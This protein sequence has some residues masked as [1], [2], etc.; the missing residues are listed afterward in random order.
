MRLA[1]FPALGRTTA[2]RQL[3][4]VAVKVTVGA[5]IVTTA[6]ALG[7][8]SLPAPPAHATAALTIEVDRSLSLTGDWVTLTIAGEV[9]PEPT[10]AEVVVRIGGPAEP[11]QVGQ[12]DPQLPEAATVS[13][14]LSSTAAGSAGTEGA[15]AGQIA[16]G[17]ATTSSTN[18]GGDKQS[19]TTEVILAADMLTLPGAYLVT[20][21]MK[22]GGVVEARGT[23]WLGKVAPREAPLDL[24]FVWPVA[25]GI[26]RDPSGAFYDDVLERAVA[27]ADQSSSS[28]RALA[29]LASRF[30]GW[31]FTL[32]LEPILLTQLRDMADGYVRLDAAGGPQQVAGDDSAAKNALETLAA[33]KDLAVKGSV[34]VAV[35]P[36][37]GPALGALAAEGWRDGLEQIQLGKQEL[38][39]TL[40]MGSTLTGAYSSDLDMTTESLAFYGQASIDHVVVDGQLTA[41]LAEPIADDAV[42]ARVRDTEN[43]RV[44]LVFA[45][46]RLRSL[47]TPP[48]DTGVFFAGLAA[49]LAAM[50]RNALVI[51]PGADFDIPPSSYLQAIG[52]TLRRLEWVE[53]QTLTSL[54]RAHA[55]A[56]RPVL[57][58]R[59][60]ER[61]QG[62][63]E[64]ALLASLRTAHGAVTDL[65]AISDPTRGPVENAHRL[66][67]AAESRWWWQPQTSPQ[68]A[69]IGLAYAE[70][71]RALAQGELDK[72]RFAGV[73]PDSITGRRGMVTF[74]VDNQADY[75]V[76]VEVQ[77]TGDGLSLPDG[78]ELEVE[79]QPGRNEVAVNV[80]ASEAPYRL[81]AR[82]MAGSSV[83][84]QWSHSV[85]PL[86][87][88]TFLP[89]VV[90]GVVVIG[91]GVFLVLRLQ[92]RKRRAHA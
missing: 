57:L 11:S 27:P 52:S 46:S 32:A 49:E 24:A 37:S 23:A 15:T 78:E 48:W 13:Q 68:V 72:V 69:S 34:E 45:D 55:P 28:V 59:Y 91:G 90:L 26:H 83:L 81:D 85:R 79:L 20:V 51:V 7:L 53:T 89:W 31:Q 43:D 70:Q 84:D 66:L 42:A 88:M 5:V 12:Q 3:L 86:T 61:T 44:T 9:S 75:S 58:E 8:L 25:L 60:A 18:V 2:S 33:L 6:A 92:R 17:E 77:L 16:A 76:K 39:Q 29:D 38:Q 74:A 71:A 64:G 21:E 41:Y 4:P 87:V 22:S 82:L 19:W 54:L 36:Y 80:L 63:I 10:D 56:T 30:P 67:Y 50:P 62:Y 14:A 40:A 65:A 35:S 47:M 1:G 73:T